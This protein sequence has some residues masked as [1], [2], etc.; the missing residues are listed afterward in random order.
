MAGSTPVD[1]E[2]RPQKRWWYGGHNRKTVATT[3][4]IA[5]RAFYW[6]LLHF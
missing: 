2:R 6:D 5:D 3:R 1:V 4:E